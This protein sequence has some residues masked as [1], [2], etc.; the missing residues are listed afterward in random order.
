[1]RLQK[2]HTALFL[3]GAL[4]RIQ[5]KGKQLA[6]PSPSFK[7]EDFN[8]KAKIAYHTREGC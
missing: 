1:M 3:C 8:K 7:I 2:A 4:L 5:G 6:E